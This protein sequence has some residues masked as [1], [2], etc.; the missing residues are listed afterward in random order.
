MDLD[1]GR[2]LA[3]VAGDGPGELDVLVL[4]P[5]RQPVDEVVLAALLVLVDLP[6]DLEPLALLPAVEALVANVDDE[7]KDEGGLGLA[8][9]GTSAWR[10]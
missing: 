9:R 1:P 7:V 3:R 2:N 8:H 4:G 10:P 6:F 5:G